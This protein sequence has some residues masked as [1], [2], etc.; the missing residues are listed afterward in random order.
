MNEF[1]YILR[2]IITKV[3]DWFKIEYVITSCT[4]FCLL[5]EYEISVTNLTINRAT[6]HDKW[7]I[8]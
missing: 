2:E 6:K 4:V 8:F 1:E 5:K 3:K 7:F